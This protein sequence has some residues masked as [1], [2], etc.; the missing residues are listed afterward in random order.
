[1]LCGAPVSR[2]DTGWLS[3]PLD[4][5]ERA[6]LEARVD[7]ALA[8]R[9]AASDAVAGIALEEFAA[10]AATLPYERA[11]AALGAMQGPLFD[12]ERGG[13]VARM[14][15]RIANLVMRPFARPQ[16]WLNDAIRD[17]LRSEVAAMQAIERDVAA[18][19][20]ALARC[21]R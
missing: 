8:R 3:A 15:K 13:P 6:R 21:E 12:V 5:A 11:V 10:T 17:A 16:Q 14:A 4:A 9:P 19:A 1:M 18:T 7:E 20:A 2:D